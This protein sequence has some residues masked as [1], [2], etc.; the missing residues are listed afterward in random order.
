MRPSGE[1]NTTRRQGLGGETTQ[2]D[3]LR[4]DKGEDLKKNLDYLVETVDAIANAIFASVND[5]PPY[6]GHTD[7]MHPR[8]PR[9][10]RTLVF[11][12][13]G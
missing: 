6:A 3:P 9:G 10:S 11:V 4:L 1:P 8:F 2:L 13:C 7:S 12:L 5:M